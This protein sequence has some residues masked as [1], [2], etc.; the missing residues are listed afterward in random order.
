MEA[1]QLINVV[2]WIVGVVP[3]LG[4]M[5][6]IHRNRGEPWRISNFFSALILIGLSA[7]MIGLL[8]DLVAIAEQL[9][10]QGKVT[11]GVFTQLRTSG[12]IWL[13]LFP[14][15]AGGV[16]I[17]VLSEFLLARKP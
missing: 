15:V 7:L 8:N 5:S 14:A 3:S 17:N 2:G 16:G 9:Y 4:A 13:V 6:F 1:G 10:K 12:A 11:D